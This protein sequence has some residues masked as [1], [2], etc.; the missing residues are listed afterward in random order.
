MKCFVFQFNSWTEHCVSGLFGSLKP[1][2][3]HLCWLL[4]QVRPVPH[5][6]ADHFS[7]SRVKENGSSC[8]WKMCSSWISWKRQMKTLDISRKLR[9][10]HCIVERVVADSEQVR[11]QCRY[12]QNEEGFCHGHKRRDTCVVCL[13][14]CPP[15]F[16]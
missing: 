14:S 12:R 13:P 7:S 2:P 4:G 5:H 6:S 15:M 16:P 11:V 1:K 8:C 3:K 9:Y 10:D